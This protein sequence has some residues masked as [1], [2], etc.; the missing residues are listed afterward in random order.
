MRCGCSGGQH[1]PSCGVSPWGCLLLAQQRSAGN[2]ASSR[3]FA[4]V[5]T[6]CFCG[7]QAWGGVMCIADVLVARGPRAPAPQSAALFLSFSKPCCQRQRRPAPPR[8]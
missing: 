2:R 5:S 1:S 3:E 6:V 7:G 4:C 8:Q